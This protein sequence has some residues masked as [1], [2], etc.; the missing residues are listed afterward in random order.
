MSD[1]VRPE[2]RE[3]VSRR[4]REELARELGGAR[5]VEEYHLRA[6]ADEAARLGNDEIEYSVRRLARRA[7]RAAAKARAVERARLE[8]VPRFSLTFRIQHAAMAASVLF[9]IATGIP[10]KFYDTWVGSLAASMDLVDTAKILHRIAAAVMAVT[11][12]YHVFW[13]VFTRDGWQNFVALLPRTRDFH[14]LIQMLRILVGRATERP[15]FGRFNFIE[16]FDYWAVYWGVII[17]LGTGTLMAFNTYFMNLLGP[18]SMQIAKLIHSDEALLA[19]L[20]L[21]LWHFYWAHMNP[22]KFPMNK[23]FLTGTMS[24]A[25]MIHE[26]P[27]ELEP[28]VRSGEI[29]LEALDG[30]PEW[31]ALHPR[32]AGEG[33][34]GAGAA[35]GSAEGSAEGGRP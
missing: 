12:L 34:E 5:K 18:Y 26:H 6:I 13:V 29:P 24:V 17:M 33:T 23:T 19:S 4:V 2:L 27:E 9:L 7:R 15:R 31:R 16:K 28:R 10:I 30:F 21:I 8:A 11:T 32:I 20:A 22:E 35:G 3:Y 14:D 1:S 25:E